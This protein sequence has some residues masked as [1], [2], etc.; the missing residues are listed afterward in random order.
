MYE[1]A[2]TQGMN[3]VVNVSSDSTI[4]GYGLDSP[5]KQVLAGEYDKLPERWPLATLSWAI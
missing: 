5:Y 2:R 3:R 1:A 4:L